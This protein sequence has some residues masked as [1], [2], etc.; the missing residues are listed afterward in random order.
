MIGKAL[1][2]RGAFFI[3]DACLKTYEV[4]KNFVSLINIKTSL[5]PG[6]FQLYRRVLFL[7]F[8]Q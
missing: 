8:L 5:A 4:S 3:N 6:L 1:Q 7:H 2:K